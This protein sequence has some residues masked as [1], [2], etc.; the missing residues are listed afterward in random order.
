MGLA[1]FLNKRKYQQAEKETGKASFTMGPFGI[2]EGAIPFAAQDLIR[3]IPS[4]MTGSMIGAAIAMMGSVGD[5]VAHGGPIVAVIGAV[6]NVLMFF[7]AAI[8]GTIITGV[9][10]NLLKRDV[11]PAGVTPEGVEV[12]AEGGSVENSEEDH[13]TEPMQEE[14]DEDVE[15][16]KLTDIL[17]RDLITVNVAGLTQDEVVDEFI[18]LLDGQKIIDSKE[19]FK[20][21]IYDREKES[22]IGLGMNI[23][24]PHAKSSAVK[25]PAVVFEHSKDGIDWKS[26]DGTDAKLIFMIAVPEE[27][28][29]NVHLRILQ[30]L[31]RKLMDN[32]F[33]KQ[34]LEAETKEEAYELLETVQ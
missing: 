1:T 5:R 11:Q 21:A 4:I 26:L 29:G 8:I 28:A 27:R 14:L 23:A 6:D 15:I 34:L 17:N 3:V 22:S 33:R 30:M 13:R 32:G 2:T 31:S 20:Q 18:Q 9:M 7:I 24:I 10:V 19:T 25:K 12:T 16:H